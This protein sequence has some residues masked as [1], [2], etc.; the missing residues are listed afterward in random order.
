MKK[1]VL[2][3]LVSVM[4]HYADV[5]A[6]SIYTIA[7]TGVAGYNGDT[8][9]ATNAKV[10]GPSGIAVDGAGNTYFSDYY[11]Q[12]VR[13]ISSS[14]NISTVAG[15]GT[16]MYNGDSVMASGAT[17]NNPMGLAA[18]AYGNVYI[19]DKGNNRVRKVDS[20]GYITTIAGNG[21]GG[22]SGDN[23]PATAAKLYGPCGVAVDNWGNVYIADQ[24][25][26]AVRKVDANG[27]ITTIA[28]TG[29]P[30]YN[31]DLWPA[32]TLAN[33][34]GPASVAVDNM[35]NV[36]IADQYNNRIR[37]VDTFNKISTVF[38][39]GIAGF[40]ADGGD[41]THA[42]IY[43]P[44]SVAVDG[45]GNIYISDELNYMIRK[46]NHNSN[47]SVTIAGVHNMSGFNGDTGLAINALIGRCKGIAVDASGNIY[48][49]DWQNNRVNY[50]TSTIAAV[51]EI[52][53]T[54]TGMEVYPN[55]NRGSFAVNIASATKETVHV[56]IINA[57]GEKVDELVSETNKPIAMKET[58]A[59]GVYFVTATS[60][61]GRVTSRV[62]IH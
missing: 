26:N 11:N 45:Y 14:G 59:A 8:G 42:E 36:Y 31:G 20:L 44:S 23:G 3:T 12:R 47:S 34:S 60:V 37:K 43:Q 62:E 17:L 41:A 35:G 49:S 33:L 21:T 48:F 53:G 22:Y 7:G 61:S 6:Q 19:A 50:I 10:F 27:M 52:A 57:M 51:K 55:P 29:N 40:T 9:V 28:G 16:A 46:V 24:S 1:I 58:V 4:V 18:D 15:T 30:G 2:L 38:G 39:N 32:A 25:N 13:K 54:L 56:V 5:K